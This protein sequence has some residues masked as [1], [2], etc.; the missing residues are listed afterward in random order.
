M[1]NHTNVQLDETGA[2][3]EEISALKKENRSLSRKLKETGYLVSSYEQ[4]AVFQKSVYEA[5]KKQKSAQD[6]YLR[7]IFSNTPDIIA[8]FDLEKMYMMG[9]KKTLRKIGIDADAL[10]GKSF[11]AIFSP[12]MPEDWVKEMLGGL[13]TALGTG[14]PKKYA[15]YPTAVGGPGGETYYYEINIIPFRDVGGSVLGAVL[16]M[17]DET[18]LHEAV[19]AAERSNRA[20]TN[21][22]AKIS[23]EIRTPMNAIAGMAELILREHTT[24]L[25]REHAL[26]IKQ[27]SGNLMAIINDVLDFSK[28]ES[29]KLETVEAGYQFAS[30]MND[31]ISII[32]MRVIDKQIFFITNIDSSIPAHLIGDE[33]RIRQILLNLLSNAFKYCERG[34]ISIHACCE[35]IGE[36]EC[37]VAFDI[38]DSGLGIKPEDHDKLFTDFGQLDRVVNREIEGTGLGLVITKSLCEAMGGVIEVYSVYG[39]GSTFTVKIPQKFTTYKPFAE[40]NDPQSKNVLIYE[41]RAAYSSSIICSIDNLNVGCRLVTNQSKFLEALNK[42][43]YTHVFVSSFLFESTEKVIRNLGIDITLVLLAEYGESAINTKNVK[44]L[45]MPVHSISI[46]NLLNGTE[47]LS[48]AENSQNGIRFIAPSA[49]ILIVDDLITN[50]RVAEGLM[51]PYRMQI[52]VCRS[53]FEAIELVKQNKYDMVFMDHMMPEM[54]GI[55]TTLRIRKM[56]EENARYDKLPI[57]ALTANAVSGVREMFLQNGFNDFLAKPVEMAKLNTILETW[58]PKKKREPYTAKDTV[59]YAPAFEIQGI[60]VKSGVYMTGGSE[61]QYLR[62]LSAFYKDGSEKIEQLRACCH[63]SNMKLYAASAHA[64]KGAAAMIGAAKL[65]SFAKALELAAK[66][67]DID[68]VRKNNDIFIEDFAALLKNISYVITASGKNKGKAGSAAQARVH[69]LKLRDALKSF[70]IEA[71]DAILTNLQ[72][73]AWDEKTCET[74]ERIANKILICEYD[75]ALEIIG[76]AIDEER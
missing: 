38:S 5:I 23:H 17:H 33:I 2:L 76:D 9:A 3:K 11:E 48:Y 67:E 36:G 49:H 39:K 65:S 66:N 59:M 55:E 32:R 52:D 63:K 72:S 29:G 26:S 25:I 4:Y 50:L 62:A 27:A 70:D 14:K 47:D 37:V 68:Y 75:E 20:K 46:A 10:T 64:V 73:G 22:L 71:A 19:L 58:L 43:K 7:L 12:I 34:F 13:Q 21:F 15:N 60:D 18:E 30:L 57:V 51:M 6:I 54:D 28:I 61:T 42:R 8:V 16:N 41:T 56:G 74:L 31:V 24:G 69:I 35:E 53:G 45:E 1:S 40:V 44:T